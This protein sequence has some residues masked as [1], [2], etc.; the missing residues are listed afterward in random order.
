M[1]EHTVF[2]LKCWEADIVKPLTLSKWGKT[3]G[4]TIWM[5]SFLT[6]SQIG[7]DEHTVKQEISYAMVDIYQSLKNYDKAYD[8][9]VE[10]A[11]WTFMLL[12]STVQ[13][14]VPKVGNCERLKKAL[15]HR[16]G[17]D[18]LSTKQREDFT[19]IKDWLVFEYKQ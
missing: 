1:Y 7:K 8:F 13:N 17:K 16:L 14:I 2:I 6:G 9:L 10:Q 3:S 15:Y 11:D 18:D 5:N 19:K 12:L 4:K